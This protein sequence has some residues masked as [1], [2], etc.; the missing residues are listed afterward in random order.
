M[1]PTQRDIDQVRLLSILYWVM[2]GFSILGML[3]I[4]AEWFVISLLFARTQEAQS[5]LGGSPAPFP[6]TWFHIGFGAIEL[7]ILLSTIA[8]MIAAR[9]LWLFKWRMYCIVVAAIQCLSFPFGTALGVFTIV[10]LVR[11]PTRGLFMGLR[12][13]PPM[14]PG[15][16]PPTT[17]YSATPSSAPIVPSPRLT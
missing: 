7:F 4:G 2:A 17:P 10:V 6:V 1:H 16:A 13:L 9:R 14:P 11:E 15:A 5:Q 3:V 12:P 8:L